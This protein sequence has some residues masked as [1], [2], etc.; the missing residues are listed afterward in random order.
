MPKTRRL[1]AKEIQR[2]QAL[3]AEGKSDAEISKLVMRSRASVYKIRV[4]TPRRHVTSG[5]KHISVRLTDEEYAAF[6]QAMDERGLTLSGGGRRLIRMAIGALDLHP[7]EVAAVHEARKE[8]NAVG[9]NLNQLTS[10][11]QSDRLQWNARDGKLVEDLD[12]RVFDVVCKL[13]RIV[14]AMRVKSI[15]AP[16]MDLE[17]ANNG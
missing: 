15:I 4:G 8:L 9:V 16:V 17:A 6:K 2:I 3:I 14:S 7:E 10:L 13:Q 5:G 1:S 12:A 11:A